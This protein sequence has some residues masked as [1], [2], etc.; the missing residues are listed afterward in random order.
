MKTKMTLAGF[1]FAVA[2]YGQS[3]Y[4]PLD[5][6][7]TLSGTNF[8][9]VVAPSTHQFYNSVSTPTYGI[10]GSYLGPTLLMNKG[11]SVS[12]AV[13]NNLNE[14]TTMHWHGM[15][16]PAHTD[17]GP[18]TV[19]PA[20]TT[21]QIGYKVMNAAST[22][23]YHPH[24]HQNTGTQVYMGLAGMII[25][26][27]TVEAQLNLPRTYGTDDFPVVLQDRSFNSNG[28][29]FV[30]GLADSMIVNGTAHPYLDC[31]AQV[32]R[33]RLLN[34][35]NVRSYNLGFSDNRSF[36]VIASDGGLL[37][38]P[39]QATRLKIAGGER[40][41]ILLDLGSSLGNSFTLTSYAS[42]FG[43]NEPGGGGM[44]NG[45]SPLN[46]VDFP[47]MQ[48]NVV[49]ATGSPVTQIPPTLI[50]VTPWQAA[51]A[52]RTR[53]KSI[54]GMGMFTTM[55]NFTFNN[56]AFNMMVINDT[57]PLNNLEIWQFTNNS[58][59]AHPI[60][61]HDVPFY[62]LSR[63]GNA[64]PAI[65]S[66]L[67]DVFYIMPSEVVRVIMKFE[68]FADDTMPYMYHCHNLMHEDNGMMAQFIVVN[69]A[70][71][72]PEAPAG[73]S[74]LSVFPNPS[75]G[76]F[77]LQLGSESPSVIRMY[78]SLGQLVLEQAY[79]GRTIMLDAGHPANG[80][81]NLV[82][83]QGEKVMRT[84]LVVNHSY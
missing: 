11:D 60:H 41:E 50:N 8:N 6:P 70:T 36:Y 82:V 38:Q 65:E 9:L 54:D 67:K 66:G 53:N 84:K 30:E 1:V 37:A 29:F 39:F 20:G 33:L 28:T 45:N 3:F 43:S 81:Y 51:N 7:P 56:T 18:H 10:N 77:H 73:T 58:N 42:Q 46:G 31:P 24:M 75:G 69:S 55:A 78:N 74:G 22:C 63:N 19:I 5:I 23:W 26:K 72:V 34:G 61:I 68:D 76:T 2:T 17:G 80:L 52:N 27:D 48:L 15:H 57:I 14:S 12:I 25:V 71:T 59:L 64:P 35:S 83:Q 4:N 49:A 40:Y 13:T 32:V 47:I 21:W 16:V 79:T 62:V 44:P